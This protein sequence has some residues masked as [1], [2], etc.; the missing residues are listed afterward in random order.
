MKE[1]VIH[2]LEDDHFLFSFSFSSFNIFV[3][4]FLKNILFD[5]HLIGDSIFILKENIGAFFL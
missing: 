4:L 3:T 1:N 5:R 2:R